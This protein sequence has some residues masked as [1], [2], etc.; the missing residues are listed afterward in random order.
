[1][2]ALK[3]THDHSM[4]RPKCR[5]ATEDI[6]LELTTKFG[7]N[8]MQSGQSYLYQHP[9]GLIATVEDIEGVLRVE[10]QF[11]SM[12]K[13]IAPKI[14]RALNTALTSRIH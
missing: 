14:R 8:T 12:A 10:L 9:A 11:G 5:A 7:G 2:K 4:D 3:I 1:M 13:Y 6:L